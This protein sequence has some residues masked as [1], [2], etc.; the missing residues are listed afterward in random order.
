MPHAVVSGAP[1]ASAS[2]S[3]SAAVFEPGDAARRHVFVYG[4]LRRG[5]ANDITRLLP[6]PRF[7]GCAAI[8]GA[9]YHLGRYP[10]VVLAGEGSVQGEIYAIDAELERQLDAIEEVYPQQTGEYAKREIG[11]VLDGR[12]LR[13]IV[14]EINPIHVQHAPLLVDGDWVAAQGR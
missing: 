14:Y 2:A 9:M 12:E 5:E 13:C 8:C 3:A 11:V 6:S 7:V 4:T 10:G 1:L